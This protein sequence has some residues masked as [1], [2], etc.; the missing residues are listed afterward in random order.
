MYTCIYINKWDI[1]I[2]PNTISGQTK[3]F[4]VQIRDY[5]F[6]LSIKLAAYN[7]VWHVFSHL[8]VR[9]FTMVHPDCGQR[10]A[11]LLEQFKTSVSVPRVQM[12]ILYIYIY[13]HMYSLDFQAFSLLPRSITS[14]TFDPRQQGVKG[15]GSNRSREEGEGLEIEATHVCILE[16]VLAY[17]EVFLFAVSSMKCA[18]DE[19]FRSCRTGP[20]ICVRVHVTRNIDVYAL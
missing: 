14:V 19:W 8:K 4:G 15:H 12:Y 10:I 17:R 18:D 6:T 11:R 5:T 2:V 9:N 20:S 13:V 1:F 16:C 3:Y 7:I